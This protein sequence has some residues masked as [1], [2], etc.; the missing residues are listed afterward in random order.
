[1]SVT[2]NF[3]FDSSLRDIVCLSTDTKPTSGIPEGSFLRE[4][5]TG[6]RHI[7]KDALW[8]LMEGWLYSPEQTAPAVIKASPGQL[9]GII[10]ET[11]GTNDVTAQLYDDPDSADTPMTPA[12]KV[13]GGDNFGGFLGMDVAAENGI[14]MALTGGTP[15]ATVIYR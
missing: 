1:M 7:Y 12:I 2:K 3:Q 10:I 4:A 13:A 6:K 8:R 9:H 5:D 15:I 14:Y 11:D